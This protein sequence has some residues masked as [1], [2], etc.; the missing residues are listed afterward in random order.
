MKGEGER[1][2]HLGGRLGLLGCGLSGLGR[3]LFLQGLLHRLF[4]RLFQ[5]LP[6]LVAALHLR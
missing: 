1:K 2:G 4:G 5:G 3:R 6:Q